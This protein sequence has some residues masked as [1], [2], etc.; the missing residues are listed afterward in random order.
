MAEGS[1]TNEG[2]ADDGP[3]PGAPTPSSVLEVSA[4]LSPLL[5]NH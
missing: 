4:D 2:Y 1:Q 3:Q 5:A